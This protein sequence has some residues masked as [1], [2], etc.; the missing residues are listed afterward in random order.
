MRSENYY[1]ILKQE[2]GKEHFVMN[3]LNMKE[4]KGVIQIKATLLDI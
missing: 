2:K 1:K 4:C 3:A